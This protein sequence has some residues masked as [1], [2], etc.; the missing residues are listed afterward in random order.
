MNPT[1]RH[2]KTPVID[3]LADDFFLYTVYSQLLVTSNCFI[4]GIYGGII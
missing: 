1:E 4:L 3:I 2:E